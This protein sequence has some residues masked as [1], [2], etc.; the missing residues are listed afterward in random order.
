MRRRSTVDLVKCLTLAVF[1]CACSTPGRVSSSDVTPP[2]RTGLPEFVGYP[3]ISAAMEAYPG[4][5]FDSIRSQ[6]GTAVDLDSAFDQAFPTS[7]P[8]PTVPTPTLIPTW[9]PEI[10]SPDL[11]RVSNSLLGVSF[12]YRPGSVDVTACAEDCLWLRFVG[13]DARNAGMLV[14]AF[15]HHDYPLWVIA[16]DPFLLREPAL[17][18]RTP[19][20][21]LARGDVK[22]FEF[23][24]YPAY[25]VVDRT[26]MEVKTLYIRRGEKVDV[27]QAIA[28]EGI[29]GIVY[30][31]E[32]QTAT[33]EQFDRLIDSLQFAD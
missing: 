19:T 27:F 29:A 1:V 17:P 15:P 30:D 11:Y 25:Q 26:V 12:D 20:P 24:G 2:T 6:S 4:Q 7:T 28:G 3:A 31:S 32:V 10:V 5:P 13:V 18:G 21:E 16:A 14:Y 9:T 22:E 8:L 33:I 23:R